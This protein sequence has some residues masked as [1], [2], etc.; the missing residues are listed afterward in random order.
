MSFIT[1]T[2]WIVESEFE[3]NSRAAIIDMSKLVLGHSE[4]VLF[5]GPKV[6][7]KDG[8]LDMLGNVAKRCQGRVHLAIIEHPREWTTDSSNPALYLWAGDEWS[9][10]GLSVP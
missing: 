10:H 7:P 9:P 6:G 4:N 3:R 5:I 2:C 1:K 8:Y